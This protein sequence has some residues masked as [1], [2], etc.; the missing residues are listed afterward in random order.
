MNVARGRRASALRLPPNWLED[1]VYSVEHNR[2][3]A[4]IVRNRFTGYWIFW[5][6]QEIRASG[7]KLRYNYSQECAQ[8]RNG[9]QKVVLARAFATANAP[10]REG[11]KRSFGFLGS[12]RL[13]GLSGNR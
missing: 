10:P 13:G 9:T 7:H 8:V 11:R 12:G 6:E 1:G 2:E 4:L 3:N 5:P